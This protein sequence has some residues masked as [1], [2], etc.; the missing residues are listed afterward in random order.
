MKFGLFGFIL[1]SIR[2]LQSFAEPV[3][4]SDLPAWRLLPQSLSQS[5]GV[6]LNE[7]AEVAATILPHIRLTNAPAVGQALIL[8][9]SQVTT[10]I[11]QAVPDLTPTN[12]TGAAQIRIARRMRLLEET[13]IKELLTA[14]LQQEFVKDRGDLELRFTRPWVS[15]PIA[16]EPFSL[17]LLDL[18]TAGITP[19]F[20]VRFELRAGQALLGNWQ[21][22]V[23]ARIWR[24]IWVAG[25]ALQ[26]GQSLDRADVAKE[27][28][29]I[30][31][32]RDAI[33]TLNRG[34]ASIELAENLPAGAPL[35]VR[36]LRLRPVVQ[37][38]RVVEALIQQGGMTISVKAEVLEDGVPG[39]MVRARN[40]KSKR[41]FR[42]KVQNEETILVAL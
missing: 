21:V 34:D 11:R 32:L 13:E 29:D 8:T 36:S 7:V 38:G 41:E 4:A 1:L 37:R 24:D 42:G 17:N 28:R 40:L 33:A 22:P 15:A 12:W 18:P 31:T 27:R 25:S 20:V 3:P 2:L 30:L 23:Q 6:Y 26:R 39:Q 19:N 14:T 35:S 5:G 10:L 9:R 16:D